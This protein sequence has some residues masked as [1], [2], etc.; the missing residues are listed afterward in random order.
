[1]TVFIDGDG[2]PVVG[3]TVDVCKKRGV[4]CV[5]LC[6]TSHSMEKYGVETV[7]VSKGAD[8]VDFALVN[9]LK[10]GDLVVSQDYGLAAMAMAKQAVPVSQEGFVYDDSNIEALLLVRHTAKKIRNAGGRL[11]G[12]KKRTQEQDENFLKLLNQLL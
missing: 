2:C 9:L 12:S 5:I 3:I 11:R 4:Y 7:V 1:M 10:K 6:D 8:S